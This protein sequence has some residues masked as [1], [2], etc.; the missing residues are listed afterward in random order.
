MRLSAPSASPA[1]RPKHAVGKNYHE[2]VPEHIAGAD[3]EA[4]QC[5]SVD[6]DRA[7]VLLARSV[8]EATA[9]DKGITSGNLRAKIDTMY[10][11][12][13]VP[14]IV[15]ARAHE[16]RHL[17]NDM[18]HG[19]FTQPVTPEEADEI[20]EL[21]DEVLDERCTNRQP[22]S[23]RAKRPERRRRT[24]TSRD[25]AASHDPS[26]DARAVSYDYEPQ[27]RAQSRTSQHQKALTLPT[28]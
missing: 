28:R 8:A 12:E 27:H 3:S 9:K 13:L 19:D 6:A 11:Q 18:A 17:G 21:M 5:R 14:K 25:R 2:D 15:K 10:G 20:L 24:A 4:H 22:D 16:I 26:T 23:K 1:W 7:A